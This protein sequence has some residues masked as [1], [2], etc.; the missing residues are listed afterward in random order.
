MTLPADPRDWDE[1]ARFEYEERAAIVEVLGKVPRARAEV[2]AEAIVRARYAGP[3]LGTVWSALPETSAAQG[4]GE[5]GAR[6]SNP[7]R[8]HRRGRRGT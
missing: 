5:W 2:Q 8:G 7:E 6:D 4:L 1:E 3:N